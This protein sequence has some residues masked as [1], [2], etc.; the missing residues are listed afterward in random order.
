MALEKKYIKSGDGGK[1][2]ASVTTGFAQGLSVVKD[3]RDQ[4]I[5]STNST[6][7]T[8]RRGMS[9]SLVSINSADP[10]LLIPKK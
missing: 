3:T 4:I 10:G 5:G 2:L 1:I 7:N 6:F 9:G 8:T